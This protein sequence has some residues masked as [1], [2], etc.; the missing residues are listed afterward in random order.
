MITLYRFLINL[1]FIFSPFILI[2]R[3]LKK[4]ENKKDFKK[5]YVFF[6]KREAKVSFYGFMERV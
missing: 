6:R 1:V 2:F 3:L 4:K 5:N